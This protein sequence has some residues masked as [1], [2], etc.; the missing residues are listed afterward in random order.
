MRKLSLHG[1]LSPNLHYIEILERIASVSKRNALKIEA[2][3]QLGAPHRRSG[4]GPVELSISKFFAATNIDLKPHSPQQKPS[5][6]SP[7]YHTYL[8]KSD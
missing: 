6:L 2:N 5:S 4:V 3:C 1:Y 8:P 7:S